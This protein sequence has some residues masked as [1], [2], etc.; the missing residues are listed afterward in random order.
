MLTSDTGHGLINSAYA[1]QDRGTAS[2]YGMPQKYDISAMVFTTT[3][4][5]PMHQ[6]GACSSP[7][8]AVKST[9]HADL[10]NEVHV[11]LTCLKHAAPTNTQLNNF[12]FPHPSVLFPFHCTYASHYFPNGLMALL[13]PLNTKHRST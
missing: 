1:V 10:A 4:S 12:C 11:T 8:H 13:D 6:T 7:G 9:P 3:V 5:H 2:V